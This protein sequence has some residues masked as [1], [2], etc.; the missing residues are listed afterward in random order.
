MKKSKVV[1]PDPLDE[2]EL[3]LSVE[4]ADAGKSQVVTPAELDH[5]AKTGEWPK[6]APKLDD[7]AIALLEEGGLSEEQIEYRRWQIAKVQKRANKLNV[8]VRIFGKTEEGEFVL[9]YEAFPQV[10]ST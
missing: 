2:E 10:R 6:S 1:R 5:W 7:A 9:L 3:R 4:E 8:S